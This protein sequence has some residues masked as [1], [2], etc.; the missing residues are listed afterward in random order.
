MKRTVVYIMLIILVGVYAI[1]FGVL[2]YGDLQ[3]SRP[4]NKTIVQAPSPVTGTIDGIICDRIADISRNANGNLVLTYYITLE[5]NNER[6]NFEVNEQYYKQLMPGA[7]AKISY[8]K[9]MSIYKIEFPNM[10]VN[11]KATN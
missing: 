8:E 6:V 3:A 9:D 4:I 5:K 1:V 2:K 10:D 7:Y 11:K